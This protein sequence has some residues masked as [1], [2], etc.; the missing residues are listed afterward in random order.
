MRKSSPIPIAAVLQ[1]VLQKSV[2]SGAGASVG[3]GVG[4]GVGCT[5]GDSVGA[6]VVDDPV[7]ATVGLPITVV[8]AM[9][10]TMA[11]RT[12]ALV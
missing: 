4:L 8:G 1:R 6:V 10:E 12:N 9:H 3:L 11:P 7:G 2:L 5:E